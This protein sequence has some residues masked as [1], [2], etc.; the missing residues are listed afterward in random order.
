M[1]RLLLLVLALA[2]CDV[3][4]PPAGVP[5][6]PDHCIQWQY[7]DPGEHTNYCGKKITCPMLYCENQWTGHGYIASLGNCGYPQCEGGK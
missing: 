5:F 1:V 4:G 6:R 7:V 3:E 2:G